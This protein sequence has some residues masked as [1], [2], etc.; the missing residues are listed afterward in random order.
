MRRVALALVLLTG[1]AGCLSRMDRP[2]FEFRVFRPSVAFEPHVVDREA[3]AVR[4]LPLGRWAAEEGSTRRLPALLGTPAPLALPLPPAA[5]PTSDPCATGAI[6][7]ALRRIEARL[8]AE[9]VRPPSLSE[10][11]APCP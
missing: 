5:V 2:G 10:S 6:L 9:R 8:P 7:S 4:S 3:G 11:K 1:P